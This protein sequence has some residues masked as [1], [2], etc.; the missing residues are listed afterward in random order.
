MSP[1]TEKLVALW[2]SGMTAT[3]V[4][5]ALGITKNAVVGKV[6]RLRAKGVFMRMRQPPTPKPERA[7]RPPRPPKPKKPRPEKVVRLTPPALVCV[8]VPDPVVDKTSR[9]VTL[10]EL[11][12]QSCR[13]IVSKDT[14]ETLYCGAPRTRKSYCT[15]HAA[16]CYV[17]DKSC[18]SRTRS[19]R[20][21]SMKIA[22]FGIT[23]RGSQRAS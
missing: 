5:K 6:N 14:E 16:L 1:D 9:F 13:Y 12:Q 23:I 15:A 22:R 2:N 8:P 19:R 21:S 3:E 18:N 17:K 4:G 11:T 10:L 7:P 20:S